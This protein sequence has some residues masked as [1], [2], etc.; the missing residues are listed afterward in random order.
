MELTVTHQQGGMREFERTG[1]YPEYLV[2]NLPGTRQS[3]R[4]KLRNKMQEGVLKSKGVVVYEYIFD[5]QWCKYRKVK[6]DGSFSE[7]MEPEF[8]STEM[9][10]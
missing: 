4:I 5:D 7:W 8:M 1:I 10:D 6:K 9:R 2:F 3:W